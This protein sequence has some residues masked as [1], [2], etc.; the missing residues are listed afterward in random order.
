MW[1]ERIIAL[2]VAKLKRPLANEEQYSLTNGSSISTDFISPAEQLNQLALVVQDLKK[3]FGTWEVPWGK[4]NRFQRNKEG[5]PFSNA[6]PSWAVPATP[7]YMGSLNAYVSRKSPQAKAR[8]G[9]TG[10]TFVAVVEFGKTLKAKTILTG[11]ASTNPNSPHFT[12]QVK[13]YIN[14]QF[15]DIF[16]YKKDVLNAAEK[17]YRPGE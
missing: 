17:T 5:Q 11:G 16:F 13:G 3:E 6:R 15:K 12:D 10:N 4:L 2:N 8:Y 1:L 7:G 14:G 9:A